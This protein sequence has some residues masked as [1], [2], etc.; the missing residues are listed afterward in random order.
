MAK[1]ARTHLT[2]EERCQIHAHIASEKS[3]RSIGLLL[4]RDHSTIVREVNRNKKGAVYDFK[5]ANNSAVERRFLA[6]SI[7]DGFSPKM[8]T[9]SPC[10]ACA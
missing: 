3:L 4:G 9:S 10:F 6:N 7:T 5:E 2:Y 8:I 1:E